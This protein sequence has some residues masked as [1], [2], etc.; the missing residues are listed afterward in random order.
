M[1]AVPRICG[2]VCCLPLAMAG[3]V[4]AAESATPSKE[5]EPQQAGQLGQVCAPFIAGISFA[6][7]L[8]IWRMFFHR[9]VEYPQK[10]MLLSELPRPH[11]KTP[12]DQKKTAKMKHLL[13]QTPAVGASC[14]QRRI[15]SQEAMMQNA[16]NACCLFCGGL[17]DADSGTCEAC[18]ER[19]LCGVQYKGMKPET[20]AQQCDDGR[21]NTSAIDGGRGRKLVSAL[22]PPPRPPISLPVNHVDGVMGASFTDGTSNTDEAS[23]KGSSCG[24]LPVLASPPP[25]PSSPP[26][27][28]HQGQRAEEQNHVAETTANSDREDSISVLVAAVRASLADNEKAAAARAARAA[29][30]ASS[31]AATNKELLPRHHDRPRGS[32]RVEGQVASAS[33]AASETKVATEEQRLPYAEAEGPVAGQPKTDPSSESSKLPSRGADKHAQGNCAPCY[34]FSTPRGC[35]WGSDC[36]FCHLDHVKNTKER[37]SKARRERTKK[38]LDSLVVD[39]N[40]GQDVETIT[41]QIQPLSERNRRY[42]NRIVEKKLSRL[43]GSTSNNSQQAGD[44]LDN[45]PPP[46]QAGHYGNKLEKPN[47]RAGKKVLY[48]PAGAGNSNKSM[49]CMWFFSV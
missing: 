41:S 14:R 32:A 11:T 38:L 21:K 39:S 28:D 49:H 1:E 5:L 35:Q 43:E 18:T 23:T 40:T 19:M 3:V 37:P 33:I 26:V 31:Q 25:V 2:Y 47:P 17:C 29:R 4:G 24:P 22:V 44:R 8:A 13:S 30:A 20:K 15:H 45:A 16:D 34:F 12:Q 46:L 10:N 36:G 7:T 48:R 27:E 42:L 6:A 9:G